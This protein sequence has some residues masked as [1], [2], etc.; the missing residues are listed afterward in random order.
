MKN[1]HFNN[2]NL[3]CIFLNVEM[4]TNQLIVELNKDNKLNGK[5]YDLWKIKVT[6]LL[7]DQE[8]SEHT[9]N[10]IV[11]PVMAEGVIEAQ[12]RRALDAYKAWHKKNYR[13]RI[14][15]LTNMDDNLMVEY[16]QY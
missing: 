16:Q 12:H 2:V 5:N 15:L 1:V 3:L 6:F 7:N 13:A 14:I 8:L 11:Q 9:E 4:A 10:S